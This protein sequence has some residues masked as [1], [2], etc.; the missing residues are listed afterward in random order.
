MKIQYLDIENF[1]G[2]KGPTRIDFGSGFTVFSGRNG[3]G[4]STVC[5]A[6]EYALTGTIF[7]LSSKKERQETLADYLWWRADGNYRSGRVALGLIDE[8]GVTYC[9]ER[10]GTQMSDKS[11]RALAALTGSTGDD[12][13]SAL[14]HISRTAMIRAE[15]IAELS[16]DLAETDRF[17][18]VKAAVGAVDFSDMESIFSDSLRELETTTRQADNN[19]GRLREEKLRLEAEL[20]KA[21]SDAAQVKDTEIAAQRLRVLLENPTMEIAGLIPLAHA[22]L[23]EIRSKAIMITDIL[24]KLESI[25]ALSDEDAA[26][27][28]TAMIDAKEALD[29]SRNESE[30]LDHELRQLEQ[31]LGDERNRQPILNS[32]RELI[33]HGKRISLQG[34]KCP[35]CGST[36]SLSDYDKHIAEVQE[37]LAAETARI[38]DLTVRKVEI[39]KRRSDVQA[40][41]ERLSMKAR[42]LE[43]RL[44][45]RD[46]NIQEVYQKL[47]TANI[48]VQGNPLF[49]AQSLRQDLEEAGTTLSSLQRDLLILD[50]SKQVQRVTEL[51]RIVEVSANELA[52]LD[53]SITHLR[54]V[55]TKIKAALDTLRRYVGEVVD[56]KLAALS[57]LLQELYSR[58]KPHAEWKDLDYR[59]RGDVRRF[60]SLSVGDGLNPAF[61]FSSGQ[62]RAAG[63]AFLLAINLARGWS[64]TNFLVLDDPVQHVDDFRALHLVEVLAAIRKSGRQII[65]T[66]EDAELA[67]LLCRRLRAMEEN[68]GKHVRM[69]FAPSVGAHIVEVRSID[70]LPTRV[71]LDVA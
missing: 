31:S 47:S 2:I 44:A 27:L 60:L 49:V 34:D 56:D 22:R 65:C 21:R 63:L 50:A 3:T 28:R 42:E 5:D 7:R 35:L 41:T 51:E 59:V 55:Y 12:Q 25:G 40:Q 71:L 18:I 37:T 23:E 45:A 54:S 64:R 26:A 69:E 24:P 1:R 17:E 10:V 9:I 48:E 39:Q 33:E 11:R 36:I 53:R 29:A 38:A 67:D 6:I 32:L 46:R 68:V 30:N 62:R 66:I 14:H 8:A 43:L 61:M 19:Y 52:K 15:S 16:L 58:L 70:I 57:P 20:S 13:I 4:K